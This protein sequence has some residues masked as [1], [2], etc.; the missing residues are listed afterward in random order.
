MQAAKSA[1]GFR[2]G[3][4]VVL[5]SLDDVTEDVWGIIHSKACICSQLLSVKTHLHV[6]SV[7]S[8]SLRLH[9]C[10]PWGANLIN[11]TKEI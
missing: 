5:F 8:S 7:E 2:A 11:P 4:R 9:Q 10:L 6:S 3:F 1:A